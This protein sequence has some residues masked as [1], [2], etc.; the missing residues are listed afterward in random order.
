MYRYNSGEDT[1]SV[2]VSND[3]DSI[4]LQEEISKASEE[5]S[6]I[7]GSLVCIKILLL[8]IP[9]IIAITIGNIDGV[10]GLYVA[11]EQAFCLGKG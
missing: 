3:Q 7:Y 6:R 1:T 8:Y 5:L 10:M 2:V 4:K 9:N 11:C